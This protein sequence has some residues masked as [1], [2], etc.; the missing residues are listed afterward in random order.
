MPVANSHGSTLP[1]LLAELMPDEGFKATHVDGLVLMRSN[2]SLPAAPVFQ[3]PAIVCVAQGLKR[4]YLGQEVYSY[5]PGQFLVISTPMHF[6]CDTVVFDRAP[7]LGCY[8][9]IDL[10]IVGELMPKIDRSRFLSDDTMP[11]GMA[12]ASFATLATESLEHL[13]LYSRD[14]TESSVLGPALVRELHYWVLVSPAGSALRALASWRGGVGRV[15]KSIERI[16]V[17]YASELGVDQLAKEAAMSVSAFHS[18]FKTVAGVSP[19]QYLKNFRLHK[20]H[21]LIAL[22]GRGATQAAYEVG[23]AS[24]NQFSREFKRHFAY[25]PSEAIQHR[26]GVG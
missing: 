25:P 13:L 8:L 26:D 23:Y 4:G 6:M 5:R 2:R 9:K 18:A 22:Q 11:R 24:P 12:V 19:M 10:T 17:D 15:H 7:M 20:A 14:P 3:E 21:E 16:R 1:A